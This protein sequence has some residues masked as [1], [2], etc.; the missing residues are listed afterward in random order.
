MIKKNVKIWSNDDINYLIKNYNILSLEELMINLN[1]TKTS[2][3]LK[4][5]RLGL[6]KRGN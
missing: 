6:K 5:N 3:Y 2:I 1:T 4:S